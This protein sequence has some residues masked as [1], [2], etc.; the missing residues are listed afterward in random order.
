LVKRLLS[1][2]VR[3]GIIIY[4]GERHRGKGEWH[5]GPHFHVY[6][7]GRVD[8]PAGGVPG[9]VIKT[10][11]HSQDSPFGTI[12]YLLN[13]STTSARGHALTWFGTLGY[14]NFM[15]K[16]PKKQGMPCPLCGVPM[17]YL[18]YYVPEDDQPAKVCTIYP[19]LGGTEWREVQ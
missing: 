10:T 15:W 6:V 1:L 18:G 13:H 14:R 11:R 12:A 5:D 3:G 7:Y 4:H 2:G 19:D 8:V 17:E 16:R 9:W